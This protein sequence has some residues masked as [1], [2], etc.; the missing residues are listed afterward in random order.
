VSKEEKYK[1]EDYTIEEL[2]QI[3]PDEKIIKIIGKFNSKEKKLEEL[4]LW[5]KKINNPEN[6]IHMDYGL[7]IKTIIIIQKD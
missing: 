4:E 1:R 3:N 7:W 6:L 2:T 5:A